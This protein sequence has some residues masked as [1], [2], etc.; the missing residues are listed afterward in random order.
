MIDLPIPLLIMMFEWEVFV[1]KSKKEE[2]P[3]LTKKGAWLWVLCAPLAIVL[4]IHYAS[5]KDV[6]R[7]EKKRNER[8]EAFRREYPE[9]WFYSD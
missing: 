3:M 9:W 5:K 6:E 2:N 1:M 8:E 7:W 4:T